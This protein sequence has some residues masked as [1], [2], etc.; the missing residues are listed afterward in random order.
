MITNEYTINMLLYNVVSLKEKMSL[1][2][3]SSYWSKCCLVKFF[4]VSVLISKRYSSV[5]FLLCQKNTLYVN[6]QCH[7]KSNIFYIIYNIFH[8]KLTISAFEFCFQSQKHDF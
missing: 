2:F 8:K 3:K 7:I 4:N 5:T 6:S 1:Y